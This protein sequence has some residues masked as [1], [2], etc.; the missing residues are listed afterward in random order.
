MQRLV[1][2]ALTCLLSLPAF[3][4]AVSKTIPDAVLYRIYFGRVQAMERA[5]QSLKSKGLDNARML[6][7]VKQES[8]LNDREASL[9][10][11]IARS[12]RADVERFD[13]DVAKPA[14]DAAQADVARGAQTKEQAAQAR[15]TLDTQRD[16]IITDY[17][18]QLRASLGDE[19]FKKL[20]NFVRHNVAPK[21]QVIDPAQ[22]NKENAVKK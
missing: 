17:V 7:L 9:I 21:I 20:D 3:S 14:I 19:R 16:K 12:S 8:G 11:T 15:K 5:A 18:A 6:Q 10:K 22:I 1:W 4:Q 2:A 13:S